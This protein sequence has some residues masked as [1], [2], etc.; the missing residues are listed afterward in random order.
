M[1]KKNINILPFLLCFILATIFVSAEEDEFSIPTLVRGY[2]IYGDENEQSPP[3]LLISSK[4]EKSTNYGSR[5]LTFELDVFSN[6]APS[7][8]AEFVHCDINWNED[9]NNFINNIGFNRTSNF[10]WQSSPSSTS[11]YSYRGKLTFPNAQ[12]NFKYSGNYIIKIYEYYK[13]EKPLMEG[14]FFVVNNIS[15][16]DMY[17]TS[18]FYKADFQVANSAYN[19]EVRLTTPQNIFNS[20]LRTVVL[21]KNFLWEEPLVI[22]E[23]NYRGF[24]SDANRYFYPTMISGFASSEK[25]FYIMEV[26]AENMYRVLDMSNATQFPSGNYEARLPFSDYYRNGNYFYDDDDGA[27]LAEHYSYTDDNYVYLKFILDPGGIKSEEDVFI[28][29]TFNNWNPDKNWMMVWDE[30][31][32]FYVLKQ[33]VRRARHSYLYGTGKYNF[34]TNKFENI[35]FDLYEGNTVYANHSILAFVYYRSLDFGGYDAI[36]GT[37]VQSPIG[38]NWNR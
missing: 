37:Y 13:D 18:S 17:F 20:N 24:A 34:D 15:K 7:I 19:I 32:R 28:S 5:E 2:R 9:E 25:R 12:V 8:Y 36:I 6:I 21:Y 1:I 22:S 11:Y 14:K 10:Y 26:P 31:N 4:D 38:M 27:M 30:D 35:S 29:G 3:V 23:D 16:M 33:W